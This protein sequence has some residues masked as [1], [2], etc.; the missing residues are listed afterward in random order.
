MQNATKVKF[1]VNSHLLRSHVLL[2]KHE[3]NCKLKNYCQ[4]YLPN[5]LLQNSPHLTW[6]F[7]HLLCIIIVMGTLNI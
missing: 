6:V 1:V 3:I 2:G 5:N 4:G 7:N